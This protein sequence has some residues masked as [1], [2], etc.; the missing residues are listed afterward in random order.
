MIQETVTLSGRYDQVRKA[1]IFCTRGS[2]G[3]EEIMK[4]KP[5]WAAQNPRVDPLADDHETCRAGAG[6]VGARS[7]ILRSAR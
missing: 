6:D 4:G 2:D 5:G 7:P 1:Y 3:V